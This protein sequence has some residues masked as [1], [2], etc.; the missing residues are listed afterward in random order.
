MESSRTMKQIIEN[1]YCDNFPN[2]VS[3]EEVSLIETMEK[4]KSLQT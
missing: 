3:V 4:N 1:E 2:R